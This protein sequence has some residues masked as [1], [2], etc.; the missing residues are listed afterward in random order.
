[1]AAVSVRCSCMRA[2]CC[3]L[4]HLSHVPKSWALGAWCTGS[5][6]GILCMPWHVL[7]PQHVCVFVQHVSLVL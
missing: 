7:H 2:P 3:K 5:L 6:L 1:M 4:C